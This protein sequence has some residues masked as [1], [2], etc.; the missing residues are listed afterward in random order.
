M[1][2][3]G[4]RARDEHQVGRR[5]VLLVALTFSLACTAGVR[6]DVGATAGGEATS[7][8]SR[9]C[10]DER[11]LPLPD[12]LHASMEEALELLWEHGYTDPRA[13]VPRWVT[14]ADGTPRVGF[15]V[16]PECRPSEVDAGAHAVVFG[17]VVPVT[18]SGLAV[19]LVATC[20]AASRHAEDR[21]RVEW[22]ERCPP[23]DAALFLAAEHP[24]LSRRI[25]EAVVSEKEPGLVAIEYLASLAYVA[26]GA[27][28]RGDDRTA[29]TYARPA[30]AGWDALRR[31]VDV[32]SLSIDRMVKTYLDD[33][34]R[35]AADQE[36]RAHRAP[37]PRPIVPVRGPVPATLVPALVAYL[38]EDTDALSHSY[39]V[40]ALMD[41]GELAVPALIEV[42]EHDAR[43]SRVR[44]DF[45]GVHLYVQNVA[46]LAYEV[47]SELVG[48]YPDHLLSLSTVEERALVGADLRAY[49]A[50]FGHL[51][52]KERCFATLQAADL[53]AHWWRES[54]LCLAIGVNIEPSERAR[55]TRLAA[56][57]LD[58]GGVDAEAC[59][60][61]R[62]LGMLSEGVVEPAT[63]RFV[64]R[65]VTDAACACPTELTLSM[66]ALEPA[67][68]ADYMQTLRMRG[69]DRSATTVALEFPDEPA[70][71]RYFA[72]AFTEGPLSANAADLD[73]LRFALQH[74]R[75]LV[76]TRWY[77]AL[78]GEALRFEQSV[79]AWVPE[80]GWVESEDGAEEADEA[81][82]VPVWNGVL[83]LER[84]RWFLGVVD[85]T[86]GERSVRRADLVAFELSELLQVPFRI[87]WPPS[88]R[89]AAIARMTRVLRLSAT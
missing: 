32:D 82:E 68:V 42:V 44:A 57:R 43:L 77:R 48:L 84:G 53:P 4:E 49:W 62:V 31:E 40:R 14:L 33:I 17:V 85:L 80:E 24:E 74:L 47:L 58:H 45:N 20:E 46:S 8:R 11:Q 50:R 69:F 87:D 78:M 54:V 76:P 88:R 2:T 26:T 56:P 36:R 86:S 81:E 55:A 89:D 15:V 64:A 75:P 18:D 38:E 66:G 27:H 60:D 61:W 19:D 3:G 10:H 51:P 79:G 25:G 29:R 6:T 23:W 1:R 28:L 63:L 35:I 30:A 67:R 9:P 16:E 52:R 12:V 59:E 72:W 73:T 34:G 39:A 13:G 70:V 5:G 83:P 41:V 37:P 7:S 21:A 71:A 22:L 65:C